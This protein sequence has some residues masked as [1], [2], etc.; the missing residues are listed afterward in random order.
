MKLYFESKKRMNESYTLKKSY[1]WDYVYS[2][3]DDPDA[4]FGNLLQGV[5]SIDELRKYAKIKKGSA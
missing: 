1:L 4:Y 2:I 3:K 5:N